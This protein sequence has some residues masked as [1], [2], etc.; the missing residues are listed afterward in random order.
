M[1]LSPK[2]RDRLRGVHPALAAVVERAA[3]LTD[4]DF[5]VT[6][7]LRTQARQAE[8]VKAGASRTMNS[9]HIT[10]HAV[11][12]AALVGGSVRW[13]WPLYHRLAAAMK[14]AASELG[15]P[16]VWGGDWQSF[17]DGPHFE[18]DPGAYPWPAISATRTTA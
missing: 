2:S 14:R 5:V 7:G 13:D 18:I 3:Q 4:T 12:L 6:E 9:K 8:L 10:G 17:P 11:D 15:I 16:I 1:E